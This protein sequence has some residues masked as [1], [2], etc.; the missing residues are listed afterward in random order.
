MRLATSRNH[1]PTHTSESVMEQEGGLLIGAT[2]SFDTLSRNPAIHDYPALAMALRTM[3]NTAS[4]RQKLLHKVLLPDAEVQGTAAALMALNTQLVVAR[5]MGERTIRLATYFSQ[6]SGGLKPGEVVRSF[7]IPKAIRESSVYQ[8]VDYL[9]S[10]QA[11][12]AVA[13]WAQRSLDIFEDV[14]IVLSG[15]TYRP[16]PLSR[17]SAALQGKECIPERID[18]A[19][20]KLGEERLTLYNPSLTLGSHLFYLSKTLIKRALLT[21]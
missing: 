15:C 11:V 16:V 8:S 7:F 5:P 13:I 2:T 6:D 9:R 12:C 18:E 17:I 1:F 14:R 19:I 3:V 10:G 4:R 20:Q 21:L